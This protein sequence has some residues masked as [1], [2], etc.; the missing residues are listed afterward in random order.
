MD[1]CTRESVTEKPPIA[2]GSEKCTWGPSYWC[3]SLSNTRECN[4]IDHCS[5]RIW[6]QQTIESKEN[7]NICQYCQQ[8]I[9]ELRSILTENRT[10]VY[11]LKKFETLMAFLY[12]SL[13]LI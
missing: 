9:K 8:I 4:S 5:K 2:L 11:L 3:S 6:S 10:E 7:D 12:F 1:V 13:R